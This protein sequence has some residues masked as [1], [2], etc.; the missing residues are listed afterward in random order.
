MSITSERNCSTLSWCRSAWT[1]ETASIDL[2]EESGGMHSPQTDDDEIQQFRK[3][4]QGTKVKSEGFTPCV[5]RKSQHHNKNAKVMEWISFIFSCYDISRESWKFSLL[6]ERSCKVTATL[7]ENAHNSILGWGELKKAAGLCGSRKGALIFNRI[8]LRQFKGVTTNL[9]VHR[10]FGCSSLFAAKIFMHYSRLCVPI[11]TCW[12]WQVCVCGRGV[13]F[14]GELRIRTNLCRFWTDIARDER[15]NRISTS[16]CA[17]FF[18]K[19]IVEAPYAYTPGQSWTTLLHAMSLRISLIS[20]WTT[21][22]EKQ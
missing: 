17:R 11:A 6:M 1:K 18:W 15:L 21:G 22:M 16:H 5:K 20:H 8:N 13:G 3:L 4:F 12:V 19:G 2:R 14:H 9:P 7:L 10:I